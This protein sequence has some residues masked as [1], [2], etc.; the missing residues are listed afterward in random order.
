MHYP[1]YE[2]ISTSSKEIMQGDLILNCPLI[3]PP[4]KYNSNDRIEVEVKELNCVVMTQSCDLENKKVEIVLVCPY[5]TLDYFLSSLPIDQ[6]NA[7]GR[8][9]AI[10]KIKQGGFPGYHLLNKIDGSE[11]FLVVDFRNVYGINYTLLTELAEKLTPRSRLLP[12]YREHL[13]QAFARYFMRVGLPH[14]L[15]VK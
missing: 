2:T 15:D 8:K 11:I 3:T 7:K 4:S 12:P 1:W 10:E 13:S 6:Q 5:Y 14:N 9:N